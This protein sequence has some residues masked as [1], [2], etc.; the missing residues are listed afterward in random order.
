MLKIPFTHLTVGTLIAILPG[1]QSG[2][3]KGKAGGTDLNF[4]LIYLFIWGFAS[5]STLYRSYHNG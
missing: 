4:G 2:G 1:K 3:Q 5:L